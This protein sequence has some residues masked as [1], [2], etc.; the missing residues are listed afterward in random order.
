MSLSRHL[1]RVAAVK[2]LFARELRR[3]ENGELREQ[4][5]DEKEV[6]MTI[7]NQRPSETNLEQIESWLQLA[8]KKDAEIRERLAVFAPKRPFLEIA[9]IARAVL[10]LAFLELFFAKEKETPAT[11]VISEATSIAAE[12]GDSSTPAFIGGVLNAAASG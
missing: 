11:V 6:P 9:P 12:F 8:K 4:L 10:I 3:G 2:A 5:A 1:T 7:E